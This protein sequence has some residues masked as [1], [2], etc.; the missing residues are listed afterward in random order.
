MGIFSGDASSLDHSSYRVIS[1]YIG[2]ILGFI[3][4]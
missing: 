3:K 1:G 2:F 4:G